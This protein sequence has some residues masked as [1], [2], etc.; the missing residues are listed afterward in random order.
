MIPSP[1]PLERELGMEYYQ[2]DLPGIGGVLRETAEDFRVEEIPLPHAGEGKYLICRLTKKNW[3]LQRAVKEIARSLGISHRRIGWAGTK[4]RRAVTTQ[5]ISIYNLRPDE[6]DQVRLGDLS[7]EVVGTAPSGLSLGALAG[8][9]FTITI[10]HC[11]RE[12]LEPRVKGIISAAR[13]GFPN[14]F[15]LQRFG[16]LR[17]VTHRV[18]KHLLRQDYEGAVATYIGFVSSAEPDE[19]AFA[20]QRF[21]EEGKVREALR[22]LPTRLSY[23]RALL[24]HL[25]E[26]PG[27]F[28]G[29]LATLP[30]RLL[31]MFVS[32]YQSYLFNH[33]LSRRMERAAL[34]TPI[35]G[36]RLIFASGRV[37]VVQEGSLRAARLHHG[38]GACEIALHVPG[39]DTPPSGI[40]EEAGLLMEEDGIGPEGFREFSEFAKVRF[41]GAD[42]AIAIRTAIDPEIEDDAVTFA[43]TL[44]P[45]Q[46]ATTVCRE[47]MKS[48]PRTMV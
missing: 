17:P 8:N 13:G 48:E 30:P 31:S 11:E 1:Y 43:F 12:D 37:D 42:R 15:G 23:E 7:L 6:V 10:R 46:Y 41:S 2:S 26:K 34:D 20:R 5:E 29:A 33:M 36:D 18:G 24:H 16:S 32:A 47:F 28:K 22:S 44:G 9:R 19:A 4:D 27:D 25:D 14:Y 39:M 3:E 38:R 21:L 45:G 40:D 35:P